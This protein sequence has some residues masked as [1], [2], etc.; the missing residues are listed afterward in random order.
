M[1]NYFQGCL[2]YTTQLDIIPVLASPY[3]KGGT[4]NN[5]HVTD[6][7][8]WIDDNLDRYIDLFGRRYGLLIASQS[9]KT[10]PAAW[11]MAKFLDHCLIL[12]QHLLE[13]EAT[14]AA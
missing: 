4:M 9:V 1:V 11:R 7:K 2:K 6:I 5:S 3:L 10:N 14:N 13:R 12:Q 8:F